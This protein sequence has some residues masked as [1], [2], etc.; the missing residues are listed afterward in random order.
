MIDDK[1]DGYPL[2]D[3]RNLIIYFRACISYICLSL[4]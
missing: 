2:F 1:N 3:L 4:I